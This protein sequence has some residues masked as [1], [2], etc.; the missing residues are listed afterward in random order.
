L[1]YNQH[2]N[3]S[4]VSSMSL[5]KYCAYKLRGY[6]NPKIDWDGYFLWICICIVVIVIMYFLEKF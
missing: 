3:F 4:E 2:I 1:V 6:K 5:Y